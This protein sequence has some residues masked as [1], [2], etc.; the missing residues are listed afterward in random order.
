MSRILPPDVT[1]SE[2]N[3]ALDKFRAV[4]GAE[5]VL[6]TEEELAP[7]RDP[8]PTN[9]DER[10]IPGAV[11]F[12]STPE[13]IQELVR[14]ANEYKIPLSPVST[15]KNL[16]YGG[17]AP[18]LSGAVVV[19]TG[20]RMNKIIEVNEK[21]AY[22]LIEPGVT[23][24]DLYNHIQEKGYKLWVDVPDLGWG[25]VVGNALDRGV[26]YT[27]YGDHIMWQTG[28]EV[29]LPDGDL[30][31][32]GM[33]AIE[34]SDT[35]QLFPYGFGPYPD[36]LFT[37]SNYGIVTKM[38]I[39]LMPEP[40]G[41]ESFLITF[42]NE[43]DLKYVIDIML[44]LRIGMAPLQNVPVLRNIFMDAA[45]VSQRTEWF[46]GEGPMPK[47]AIKKMQ[48]DL[49]LGYWNFYGTVYGPPPQTDMFLGMIRD[50]F[51]QVPGSRFFT[52]TD[53]PE[54]GDRGAHVLHDRHKI[55]RGIPSIEERHLLEWVPNG[56]H[57]CFSPVS[58]PDGADAMK[59]FTMVRDRS[60]EYNQ[61]YAAQFIVGLR[62]M[63]HI[64][65]FVYDTARPE[66][67]D[68]LLAMTEVLIDEA[69]A[70]GY[71]EYR[72]HLALMDQV[73]GTFNY[74]DGALLRFQERIKDALDPNGIIAPGKSG[75][76]GKRLK[77]RGF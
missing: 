9:N 29:V 36:G 74:N 62:E 61:D 17:A 15:G 54:K 30:L 35:W 73:A 27:P 43:E 32:T 33:G 4:L 44:P 23:Y 77:G 72:T 76:W 56:G 65:L 71:G 52:T 13:E 11:V 45:S 20:R 34:G 6:A 42:E 53:R 49:N 5:H 31:R 19:A 48:K 39:A 37:Q 68:Q 59:Q 47:E 21:Y 26:G 28:L 22:A 25:S 51:L 41:A 75:I 38:G 46:D 58:A 8:F 7:Y 24:F 64:C 55:N 12:P 69:A 57:I 14:I 70:E 1:E 60:I 40:P 18:R 10:F 67:R 63:H 3:T 2:F 66:T 16:G 50:A